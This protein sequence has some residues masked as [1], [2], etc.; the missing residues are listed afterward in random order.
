MR[1]ACRKFHEIEVWL[2]FHALAYNLAAL[3]SRIEIPEAT[4]DQYIISLTLKLVR[5]GDRDIRH[6]RAIT[7]QLA[8]VTVTGPMMRAIL[9]AIQLL[10][11]PLSHI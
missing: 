9:V 10:R 1:P 2:Q 3:L 7:F 8:E 4:A 5:I 11:A 6:T